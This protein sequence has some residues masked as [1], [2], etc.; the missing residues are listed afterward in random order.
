MIIIGKT[1]EIYLM[2]YYMLPSAAYKLKTAEDLTQSLAA[3][4]TLLQIKDSDNDNIHTVKT[5]YCRSTLLWGKN[6]SDQL[7]LYLFI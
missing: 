6:N 4:L 1:V 5:F 2:F 3:L 7:H